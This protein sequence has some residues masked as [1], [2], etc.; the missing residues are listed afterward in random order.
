MLKALKATMIVFGVVEIIFGLG[1]TFFMRE[2]S[3]MLGFGEGPDYVLY[4]GALLGLALIAVSVFIIAAG[5][6]PLKHIWWVKF[7][8]LLAA[9]GVLAGVYS[10]LR[11]YVDFSQAGMGIIWDAIITIALL[12]FYPRRKPSQD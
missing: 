8:V 11:G 1:F 4:L 6:D 2:M 12:I 5:R 7:A 10:S 9:T 3:A